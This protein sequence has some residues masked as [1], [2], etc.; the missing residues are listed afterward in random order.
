MPETTP[1]APSKSFLLSKTVWLQIVLFGLAFFPPALAWLK[2][3]PVDAVAV[4]TALNVLVRFTTSGRISILPPEEVDAAETGGSAGGRIPLWVIGAGMMAGG[5][6]CLPSCSSAQMDAA[7]AIPIRV[8]LITPG[9]GIGYS[10]KSG[11]S[12]DYRSAK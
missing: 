11:L 6:G 10:S 4:I 1:P 7:R 5:L 8:T 12:V 2:A 9:G 3:N